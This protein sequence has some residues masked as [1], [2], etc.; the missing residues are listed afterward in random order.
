MCKKFNNGQEI[1]V[2]MYTSKHHIYN[3]LIDFT[4][5]K[6]MQHGHIT[7]CMLITKNFSNLMGKYARFP[8]HI[9]YKPS[10]INLN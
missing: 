4:T 1:Y 5:I 9:T 7:W 2:I 10:N 6:N 3:T 8:T